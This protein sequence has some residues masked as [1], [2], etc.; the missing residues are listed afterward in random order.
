MLYK[1]KLILQ[2]LQEASDR[3]RRQKSNNISWYKLIS[4]IM[5]KDNQCPLYGFRN[6]VTVEA[7]SNWYT[8][9]IHYPVSGDHNNK[10][11]AATYR[12]WVKTETSFHV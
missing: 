6:N 9:L 10:M 7:S 2:Y 8:C 11:D 3:Q 4:S 5:C 1:K 12:C